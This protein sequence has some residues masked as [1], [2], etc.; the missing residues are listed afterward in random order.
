MSRVIE[1]IVSPKG[2]TTVQTKGYS[3][4]S[5]LQASQWLEK[6]LGTVAAESKTSEFYQ[7]SSTDQ[8]LQQQ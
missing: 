2:E 1:L 6:A 4:S 7:T 3:G 5:C 8:H